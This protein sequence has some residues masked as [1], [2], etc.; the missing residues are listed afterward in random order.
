M[1]GTFDFNKEQFPFLTQHVGLD[2]VVIRHQ[3]TGEEI[4]RQPLAGA[5][6]SDERKAQLERLEAKAI[7]L[8]QELRNRPSSCQPI[9]YAEF[10]P[11]E[12]ANK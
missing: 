7:K 9:P 8:C 1:R 12:Q 10:T 11:R 2:E 5:Y 3:L 6:G 4:D